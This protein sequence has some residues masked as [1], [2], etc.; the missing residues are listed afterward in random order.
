MTLPETGESTM[1]APRARTFAA[2]ARLT[3]GLTVLMSMKVLP[4]LKP[5]SSPSGP[6][7]MDW[8]AAAL[9]TIA[10]M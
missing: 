4:A 6:S 3:V 1:S 10:R 2:S 5:A 8:I 9:V 7:V